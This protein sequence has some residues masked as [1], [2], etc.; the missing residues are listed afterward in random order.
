MITV[1]GAGLKEDFFRSRCGADATLIIS[2]GNNELATE[3]IPLVPWTT[4]VISF[5]SSAFKAYC[6]ENFDTD[7]DGE[8]TEDEAKAVTSIN[9]SMLDITSLVGIEYFSNLESIDVSFN[10]LESLD[11]SHSPKLKT[12]LVNGNKLHTLNL[13]GLSAMETLDCSNNKLATL[14]VS[15]SSRLL[16]LNCSDNLIGA[17]NLNNNKS[18]KELRCSN[19]QLASLSLRNNTALQQLYCRKNVIKTLDIYNLASLSFLDCSH[20]NL[21]ALDVETNSSLENLYCSSNSLTSLRLGTKSSLAI[22]DC[23]SNS[24]TDLNVLRCTAIENLNCSSNSLNSLNV[25]TLASMT[26]LSCENNNIASLD[27]SELAALQTVKCTSDKLFKLWVKNAT[28]QG[29]LTITKHNNTAI[30][31]N[32]G[33]IYLPDAKLKAYLVTNYDENGD[34][35]I[36]PAE[37]DLITSVNCSGKSIADLT[38]IEACTNLTYLNCSGNSLTK[39]NLYTLRKLETLLC[40]N[41][42]LSDINLDNCAALKNIYIIDGSTNAYSLNSNNSPQIGIKNYTQAT[43]LKFSMDVIKGRIWVYGSPGLTSVDLSNNS[44]SEVVVNENTSMN[45]VSLPS[46]LVNYFGYSCA[47]QQVDFSNC[48]KLQYI[49]IYSNQLTSLDVTNNPQLH[50][51]QAYNNQLSSLDLSNNPNM[52]VLSIANNKLT[53]I[54]LLN[55]TKLEQIDLGNNKLSSINVRTLTN[56]K[57]LSVSGNSS[58]SVVNVANNTA[59]TSLNVYGTAISAL[60]VTQNTALTSL[61]AKSTS[62]TSLDVSKNTALTSLD[63]SE[64]SLTNMDVSYNTALTTVVCTSCKFNGLKIGTYV[65]V[66][67]KKGI[68]FYSSGSTAKIVSTDEAS[69]KWEYNGNSTGATST[70]DGAANTNKIPN[71]PAAQWCRAKGTA[72]YLPARD[73]LLTIYNNKTKINTVLSSI[74]GTQLGTGYYWSSTEVSTAGSYGVSFS[75]GSSTQ[76]NKSVSYAVRAVRAL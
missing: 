54:N 69:K 26:D 35:E 13:A 63:V 40:Y 46:S 73:E 3:Y 45:S 32:D 1:S 48:P 53:S 36:S 25:S 17:L 5:G 58:I 23:S 30:L 51:I 2:D 6:V 56:L 41:N 55:S 49:Q 60:D 52:K 75:N 66:S 7:G 31:F 24:L 57:T 27:V 70:S 65:T 12:V 15:G 50:T 29:A 33:G 76:N 20:N 74:G 64:T 39:L 10:K 44:C 42:R 62:L 22:L 28:Q 18:L 68:V 61:V 72:W 9:A 67:G 38:G 21:T 71:S 19:N 8:L 47:L 43:T 34:G 16:S 14:N 59:L 37:A 11:L 4:D